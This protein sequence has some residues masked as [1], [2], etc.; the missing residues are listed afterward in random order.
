[1]KIK[2]KRKS[3][4]YRVYMIVHAPFR[5]SQGIDIYLWVADHGIKHIEW[6]NDKRVN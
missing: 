6:I 1:M 4:F 2:V 5:S 3:F